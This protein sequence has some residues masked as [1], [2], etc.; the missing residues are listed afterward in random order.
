MNGSYKYPFGFLAG[1]TFLQAL[2][3]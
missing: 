2:L 1:G 3:V